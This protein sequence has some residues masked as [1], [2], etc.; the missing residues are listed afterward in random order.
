MN[1]N[2]NNK[3][4]EA[5]TPSRFVEYHQCPRLCWCEQVAFEFASFFS[6]CS[7][8]ENRKLLALFL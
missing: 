4:I 5:A 7:S 8:M 1:T 6:S 3:S 2:D